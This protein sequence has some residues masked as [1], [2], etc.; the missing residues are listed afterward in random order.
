M[1]MIQ[2]IYN[3]ILSVYRLIQEQKYIVKKVKGKMVGAKSSGGK[4]KKNKIG[5]LVSAKKAGKKIG[6]K[7]SGSG[8]RAKQAKHK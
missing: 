6:S 1:G 5:S 2:V 3:A 4:L 7:K 8:I